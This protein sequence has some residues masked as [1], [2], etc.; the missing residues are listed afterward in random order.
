[1]RRFGRNSLGVVN[2]LLIIDVKLKRFFTF[3]C[4]CFVFLG[5]FLSHL[6]G[7]VSDGLGTCATTDDEKSCM[8]LVMRVLSIVPLSFKVRLSLPFH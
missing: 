2:I 5:W 4:S 1:M 8:L 3:C 6:L 7:P